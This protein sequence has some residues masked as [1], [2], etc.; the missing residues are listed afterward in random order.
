MER[1]EGVPDG[2]PKLYLLDGGSQLTLDLEAEALDVPD[3][4]FPV[5]TLRGDEAGT[6]RLT[7]EAPTSAAKAGPCPSLPRSPAPMPPAIA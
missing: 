3:E 2:R 7:P 1:G 5:L 4:Q 6:A